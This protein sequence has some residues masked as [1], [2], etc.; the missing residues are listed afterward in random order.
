MAEDPFR[1]LKKAHRGSKV[2]SRGTHQ[3][4]DS[5]RRSQRALRVTPTGVDTENNSGKYMEN[6][7]ELL[8]VFFA[9]S[10]V[11]LCF[12]YGFY[13]GRVSNSSYKNMF[14]ESQEAPKIL[15]LSILSVSPPALPPVTELPLLI[16]SPLQILYILMLSVAITVFPLRP[17]YLS[18]PSTKVLLTLILRL[19]P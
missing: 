16:K 14:R 9:C 10:L 13:K 18:S 19:F 11:F 1:A 3:G 12:S 17:S 6:T 7:S 15:P 8:L 4:R 5:P 2:T